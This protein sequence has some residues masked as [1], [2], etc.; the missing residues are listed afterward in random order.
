MTDRIT[1]ETD[2]AFVEV[3]PRL[4]G[5]ISAFDVKT[6]A[7]RLPI[8]RRWT[9]ESENPRGLGS[10]PMVPWFNRISGG[11][12]NFGG[13]FYPI[14]PNDPL[15]PVPLHGDG[16]SSPWEVV[17]QQAR[18]HRAEAPQQGD[19]AFRL[20]GDADSLACRARRSTWSFGS[21][22]SASVPFPYGLGQHPWFVRT[23][24]VRLQ[25][26]A[27]GMWLEQPPAFPA[28]TE[29]APIPA[30]WD[31]NHAAAPCPTISSTT[32][33]PAG[34]AA[35]GSNGPTAASR[36]TSNADPSTR[37]YHVYSLDKDC[38]IFCFEP[39]THPNN[40]LRQAGTPE[41][42]G[43]RVLAPGAETSMRMRLKATVSSSVIAGSEPRRMPPRQ[44]ACVNQVRPTSMDRPRRD[45]L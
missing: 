44:A 32:A 36:S 18:P 10:S 6:R 17:E 20:R 33:M 12:F 39:V 2:E 43:L 26:K 41:A 42:N 11:G 21:S 40:A 45:A 13:T 4:G 38:P 31:F 9:G 34:T 1:M 3:V 23:P 15:E 16:W 8:F 27:T 19:P 37:F 28:K 25:A 35:R 29:P 22:I 30:K 5:S 7:E 14:A 24:G